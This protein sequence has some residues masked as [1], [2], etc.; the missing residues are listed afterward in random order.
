MQELNE[1]FKTVN[2]LVN[3]QQEDIDH[4]ETKV[5]Q[6]RDQVESGTAHLVTAEKHQK[7]ARKKQC[8]LLF[9]CLLLVGLIFGL[10]GGFGVFKKS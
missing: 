2:V 1:A 5:V 8:M 10:M 4:I 9:C 6:T 3:E 7:S